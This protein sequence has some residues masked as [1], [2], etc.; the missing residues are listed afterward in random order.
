M[1]ERLEDVVDVLVVE[2]A[3][4]VFDLLAA[5]ELRRFFHARVID[6]ADGGDIDVIGILHPYEVAH[7]VAGLTASTDDADTKTIVRA[8]HTRR[9]ERGCTDGSTELAARDHL[10]T[11]TV[12]LRNFS[13]PVWSP[14]I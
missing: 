5:G 4:V 1:V 7:V 11:D 9:E 2:D 8:E 6:V 12:M 14:W 13:P 3:A 10:G